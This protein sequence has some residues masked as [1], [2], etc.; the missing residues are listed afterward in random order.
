MLVETWLW[1]LGAGFDWK[2]TLYVM[3]YLLTVAKS[4]EVRQVP[5]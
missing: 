5:R 4:S 1:V 2:P 3:T